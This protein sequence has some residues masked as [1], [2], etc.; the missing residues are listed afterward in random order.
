[1]RESLA[2]EPEPRLPSFPL[3]FGHRH[4][5][6]GSSYIRWGIG[7]SSRSADQ[8]RNNRPGPHRSCHVLH[9][10]DTT[11]SGALWTPGTAVHSRLAKVAQPAPA[12]SQ[13]PVPIPRWTLPSAGL[14]VTRHHRGFI[15]IHPVGLPQ[16]VAPGWNEGP[17]A[18]SP[19]FAPRDYSQRTLGRRQALY[20]GPSP[21][22][23]TSSSLL[24][25]N[26]ST[27]TTSCR[28]PSMNQCVPFQTET[29]SSNAVWQPRP[30][31]N[32]WDRSENWTS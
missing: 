24:G 30:A 17:W 7:P 16:P 22:P 8:H 10:R 9:E 32:P 27:Q 20:T 31:R 21:T 25:E 11:G 26:H 5:L 14:F 13:R 28:T 3:P 23:S 1:M 18:F 6:L 29:T 19:G 4:S 15:H 12:A 2:E